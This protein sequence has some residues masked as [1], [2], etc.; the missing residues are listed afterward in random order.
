M[1]GFAL[2]QY[3]VGAS[4]TCKGYSCTTRLGEIIPVKNTEV[5]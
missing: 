3:N 2:V 4:E 1:E 5:G